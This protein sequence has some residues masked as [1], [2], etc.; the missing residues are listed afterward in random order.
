MIL[1]KDELHALEDSLML[2]STYNQVKIEK[3]NSIS[4]SDLHSK[5]KE[6]LLKRQW[7]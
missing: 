7:H 3:D 5:I 1:T 2:L 6:E 4:C